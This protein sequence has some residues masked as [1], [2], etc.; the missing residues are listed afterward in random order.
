[1]R[2]KIKT[3]TARKTKLFTILKNFTTE[4]EDELKAQ[5]KD[6]EE[7]LQYINIRH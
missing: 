4:I 6:F 7:F 5:W 2:D 3:M 1:M